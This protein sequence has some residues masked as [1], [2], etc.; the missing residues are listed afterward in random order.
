M[1]RQDVLTTLNGIFDKVLE[2]DEIKLNYDTTAKDVDG[3]DSV[4]NMLIISAVE[5]HYNIH[6]NLREIIKMKN[7]GCLCDVVM[8]KAN[9]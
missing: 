8:K 3:W 4:S 5:E 6:L 1:E 2:A 9:C 7:V